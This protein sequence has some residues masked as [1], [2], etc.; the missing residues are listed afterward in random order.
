MMVWLKIQKWSFLLVILMAGGIWFYVSLPENLFE[1]QYAT[2][3]YDRNEN[4]LAATI[5]A[6]GQWRFPA[7]KEIPEKFEKALLNFEDKYF[8]LHPGINPV[9][10][11]RALKWNIKQGKIVSGGST[12]T[13]QLIRLSRQGKPRTYLEKL[14]ELILAVR[15]E[16]SFSKPEILG[17]YAAHAPFGGNIVGLEAAAWKYFSRH[18]DQLSWGEAAL[19]A[20]LPNSPGLI[21]PGRN[22]EQLRVKRN[23]L[24][25]QLYKNGLI[26]SLT[27]HLAQQEQIPGH[28]GT[29]PQLGQHLLTR[30]LNEG[31]RGQ[32]I[33]SSLDIHLQNQ[34][35]QL[36]RQHQQILKHNHIYNACAL[37]AKIET[38]QTLAYVGNTRSDNPSAHGHSVDIITA[39]RSTGS[40]LKPLLYALMLDQGELL[41]QTLIPDIPTIIDGFAPK[42][43][44][45]TYEGAVPA[46]RVVARSLNV[47]AV[48][49][50]RDFGVE[51]LHHHLQNLGMTTLNQPPSHYGLSLI[52][53]GAEATLWDISGIYASLARVLNH[54]FTLPEPHRFYQDDI[55]PLQYQALPSVSM[56]PT[57]KTM[58]RPGAIWHTFNAMLD[59]NRPDQ[60]SSWELFDSSQKIAWKTG[61]SFGY[62]DG[63]A[64]G[65]NPEYVVGV[66][67]GN[68]DGEGRPGLTGLEA[69]APILF[70]IFKLLPASQQW[71][72]PP[73]SDMKKVS[74][75]RYSGH[76]A[77]LICD[78]VDTSYIPG[79]GLKSQPCPFHQM[80]H[81]DPTGKYQVTSACASVNGMIHQPW[82]I[83]P[84]VQEWYFKSRN[85]FY[86][87]L[88]PF[89]PECF[90]QNPR[91]VMQIIYPANN[92]KLFI[93]KQLDGTMSESIFEVAH[94]D[95]DVTIFWH[96]DRQFL[97]STK[98]IHQMAL[99]ADEGKHQVSLVDQNGEVLRIKFEI[100]G[101]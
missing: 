97:G 64:I 38:G 53:G 23:R 57:D 46:S 19:L 48:H 15:L 80:V 4:L 63:W 82:F 2:V 7:R 79:K 76:R 13:M 33:H 49:M 16:L 71:F 6:D 85:A 41:P 44:S 88:P 73:L 5:A 94:R 18:P 56:K 22:Q 61:T 69:A 39:P 3:L 81:L 96:L 55:R 47:P 68:A 32:I 92:S 101:K 58:I 78:P 45:K 67:V 11:L 60:E 9:A 100:I 86:Q 26:D 77:S 98:R 87:P 54:Y 70:D 20:V 75:C 43:F 62:R 25:D 74:L 84:P 21:Y 34:V 10:L 89:S 17:L 42:N 36:I 1:D 95:P 52:L 35:T 72:D 99:S 37:V 93:P 51:K 28:P 14:I 29:L 59:L 27:T 40:I 8:Y 12:I 91:Q 83:L 31:R 24:L 66:W 30:N 90:S 65:I 50:L